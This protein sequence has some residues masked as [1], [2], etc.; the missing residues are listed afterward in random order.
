MFSRKF[1]CRIS[2]QLLTK[3]NNKFTINVSKM[4]VQITDGVRVS[5]ETL[6]QAEYSNPVNEHYMFAYKIKI[7]NLSELT[8]QLLK[9]HWDIF[10]SNGSHR[11]VEGE[12]VIGLQPVIEPGQC[13]EY[14][15]A[16]NLKT[17]MGSMKGTYTMLRMNDLKEMI[18]NIPEFSLTVPYKM[19]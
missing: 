16:C 3:F 8:V 5:V 10:D 14:V 4:I 9:R 15:S 18:V 7:E 17:E 13:H 6:Y 1:T 19:N 2:I 11:E 12:G